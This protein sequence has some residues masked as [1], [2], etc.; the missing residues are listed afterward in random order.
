MLAPRRI[1]KTSLIYRLRDTSYEHG[2]QAAYCSFAKCDTEAECIKLLIDTVS[3]NAPVGRAISDKLKSVMS[4]IKGI[5]IGPGGLGIDWDQ[6]SELDWQ[7]AGDALGKILE[8]FAEPWLVCVD[9]L[10][11]FI[12]N[13]LKKDE[14][15][16]QRARIF[17]YWF[18]DLRQR[19]YKL[20]KWLMAG[21]IGLDTLAARLGLSDTINDVEP[22]PLSA[23]DEA[24]ALEFLEKLSQSYE[25]PLD[26]SLR[27]AIV[28]KI[29]WPVPY[30]LQL[31]FSRIRDEC[32]DN[33]T[34]PDMDSIYRAFENLLD[35]A[36]R[37]HFDYWRQRLHEELGEPEAGYA[38][39]LL[40][41]I[42]RDP[43]GMEHDQLGQLLREKMHE[44]GSRDEMLNYLLDVLK[45]DGYLIERESRFAFRLEWLRVYWQR[46]FSS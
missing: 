18:R 35:P 46:R 32:E 13:L 42:C 20:V 25:I 6:S 27:R 34:K 37:V 31:M 17:L 1:G 15:G 41:G 43:S 8:E 4:R 40:N 24:T 7:A 11:V 22:F 44:D 29:G 16:R 26:E 3:E 19:H 38:V 14:N 23:F 10:P 2:F 21:S 30:Y 39:L 12:I 28:Q 33:G 9:E 45:S 36:Y 5:K